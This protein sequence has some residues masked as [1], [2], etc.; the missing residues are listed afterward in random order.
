MKSRLMATSLMTINSI[1]FLLFLFNI[2]C[3]DDSNALPKSVSETAQSSN[4]NQ[5][6][7]TG[8]NVKGKLKLY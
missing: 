7:S 6:T 3:A 1:L 4:A 5:G 8:A 2:S